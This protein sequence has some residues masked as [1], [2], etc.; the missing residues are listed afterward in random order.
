MWTVFGIFFDIYFWVIFFRLRQKIQSQSLLLQPFFL[1]KRFHVKNSSSK[2]LCIKSA[3][4]AMETLPSLWSDLKNPWHDSLSWTFSVIALIAYCQHNFWF[5][6]YP[7]W[8]IHSS[9]CPVC[10]FSKHS[11][12]WYLNWFIWGLG[13]EQFLQSKVPVVGWA[14]EYCA[15]S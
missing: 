7:F 3:V 4:T 15:C 14:P 1:L 6:H 8:M 12:F 9:I 13:Q 11:C 10:M 2:K 5:K